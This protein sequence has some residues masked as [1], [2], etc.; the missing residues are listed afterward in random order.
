MDAQVTLLTK[1]G[2][3]N[4]FISDLICCCTDLPGNRRRIFTHYRDS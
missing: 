1:K 3:E 4:S 2:Y